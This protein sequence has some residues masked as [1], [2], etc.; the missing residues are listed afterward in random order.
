M[1]VRWRTLALETPVR[2]FVNQR[3][4][5]RAPQVRAARPLHGR[6]PSQ[7]GQTGAEVRRCLDLRGDPAYGQ[8]RRQL[9]G[10]RVAHGHAVSALHGGALARPPAPAPSARELLRATRRQP[11]DRGERA[12]PLSKAR[13]A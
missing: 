13:H 2:Q 9:P 1:R 7:E 4:A 3:G 10:A 11:R 5:G 8:Q 12:T 6:G